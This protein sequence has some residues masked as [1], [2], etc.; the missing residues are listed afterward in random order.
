MKNKCMICGKE[1]VDKYDKVNDLNKRI[2]CNCCV[3]VIYNW[4][5]KKK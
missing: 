5:K 3:D 2:Y 1:I 4:R